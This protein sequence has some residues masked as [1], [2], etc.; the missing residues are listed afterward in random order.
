MARWSAAKLAELASQIFHRI[1]AR[2]EEWLDML[3]DKNKLFGALKAA[4]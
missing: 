4:P 2:L 1:L 3:R